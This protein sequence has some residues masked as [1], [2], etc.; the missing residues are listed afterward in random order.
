MHR[1]RPYYFPLGGRPVYAETNRQT[2][3]MILRFRFI[4]HGRLKGSMPSGRA[5]TGFLSVYGASISSRNGLK[6]SKAKK[7]NGA[8]A[9][10]A[11]AFRLLGSRFKK[12]PTKRPVQAAGCHQDL[13]T[14]E[15]FVKSLCWLPRWPWLFREIAS[16]GLPHCKSQEKD[17]SSGR[18]VLECC[19]SLVC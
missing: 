4:R 10:G 1:M 2:L 7:A 19:G 18:A 8:T 14:L 15:V 12:R 13:E 11:T 6:T 3:V 5:V 16:R 9:E 17:M